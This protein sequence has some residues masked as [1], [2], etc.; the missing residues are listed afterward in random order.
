MALIKNEKLI[1]YEYYIRY[2]SL[3]LNGSYGINQQIRA[4]YLILESLNDFY[5]K[6]LEKYNILDGTINDYIT[7]NIDGE[8]DQTLD[9]IGAIF[10][11]YRQMTIKW[12]DNPKKV[13]DLTTTKTIVLD[14][15]DFITYIRSQIIKQHFNGTREDLAKAYVDNN[16]L[17]INL[18]YIPTS[19]AECQI[20][21]NNWNEL[22]LNMQNLFLNRMIAIESMG[23]TYGLLLENVVNIGEWDLF[24]FANK[25]NHDYDSSSKVEFGV[26]NEMNERYFNTN[27][28]NI[29]V[30]NND[31]TFIQA[32]TYDSSQTYYSQSA[33]WG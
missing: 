27:K 1:T 6:L 23:I 24:G 28:E 8:A 13:E 20:Y 7:K 17:P 22:S 3:F 2:L 25:D 5:N 9:N 4:V 33:I 21:C 10:N 11:C 26:I 31:G 29:F 30:K 16:L 14:N 32:T 12:S 19:S 18:T 15:Y